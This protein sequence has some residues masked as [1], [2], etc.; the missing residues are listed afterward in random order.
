MTGNAGAPSAAIGEGG[1]DSA[2][3]PAGA[4]ARDAPAGW[5]NDQ[6]GAAVRES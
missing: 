3:R 4:A 5:S 6:L 2:G 1:P